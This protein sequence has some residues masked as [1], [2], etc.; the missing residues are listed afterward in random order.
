[1]TLPPNNE[2]VISPMHT[3]CRIDF[4]TIMLFVLSLRMSIMD[5]AIITYS[6]RFPPAYRL[7]LLSSRL[8]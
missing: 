2:T 3:A 4:F 1:M 7:P 8:H 6:L 5:I